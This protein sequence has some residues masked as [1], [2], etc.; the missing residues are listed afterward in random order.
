MSTKRAVRLAAV[1]LLAIVAG[2][3][4]QASAQGGVS[5]LP[6]SIGVGD[7]DLVLTSCG[8]SDTLLSDIYIVSLYLPWAPPEQRPILDREGPRAVR[9]DIVYDGDLPEDVPSDWAERLTSVPAVHRKAITRTYDHLRAHDVAV[10]GYAPDTGTTITVGDEIV[11]R[12]AGSGLFETVLHLWMS[13]DPVSE[14]VAQ[15]LVSG[16][17]DG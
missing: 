11:A 3:P 14:N 9:I 10:I 5:S 8:V 7:E 13:N 4:Y 2:A 16:T 1:A 12:E 15:G 6:H 17:C